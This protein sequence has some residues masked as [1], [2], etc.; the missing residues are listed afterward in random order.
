MTNRD[1]KPIILVVDDMPVNLRVLATVL[2]PDYT[3]IVAI[4]GHEALQIAEN[5]TPDM[6]LLD[7]TMPE[8]DGYEVMRRLK[9]NNK[10]QNIPVIFVTAMNEVDDETK[11]FNLGAVDYITKP[12]SLPVVKARVQTHLALAWAQNQL[13]EHNRLLEEKVAERTQEL[14]L[15][16]DVTIN[17][18]ASLAETRDNETGNHIRRTQ[19][20]VRLLAERL[21]DHPKFRDFLDVA[22]I[23]LLF[24]SA[25]LHDMGKV[26][27]PDSILLKPGKLTDE[28]FTVMKTHTTLGRDAIAIA[29]GSLGSGVSFL[30]YIQEIAYTHHEKWDGSGYPEGLRWEGLPIS[31]RLMAIA[32]VYDALISKRVYKPA[33]THEKAVA[34]I[35]EGKGNHFD[36][37]MVE[38]FLE[39]ADSF[40]DV[41]RNF[42]D[43]HEQVNV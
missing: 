35:A 38:A 28:E 18:L 39:I 19:H 26:G 37:D 3:V 7:V 22:T 2:S 11:G 32:D 13:K 9:N 14:I 33:F 41:A 10:N 29:V 43:N 6:I 31:G 24:K 25:P 17:A 34:I 15:T 42:I 36:P 40:R 16:R 23:E 1:K 5:K 8:M 4:N 12:F 30:K 20:Y 21:R 27:V